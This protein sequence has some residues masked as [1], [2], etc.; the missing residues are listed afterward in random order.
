MS[1]VTQ[2]ISVCIIIH[3]YMFLTLC[4]T[5]NMFF[6]HMDIIHEMNSVISVYMHKTYCWAR[7]CFI[8]ILFLNRYDNTCTLGKAMEHT[9]PVW[10]RMLIRWK[11]THCCHG[12][13][14]WFCV[15]DDHMASHHSYRFQRITFHF[16]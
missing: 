10:K 2:S 8:P 9:F 15:Y 11:G 14:G 13:G 4:N 7:V 16:T 3:L 5:L 1:P 12:Y 6:C